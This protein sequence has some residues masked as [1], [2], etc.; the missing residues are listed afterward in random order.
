[1]IKLTFILFLFIFQAQAR[2]TGPSLKD[3]VTLKVFYTYSH[4]K[5]LKEPNNVWK[6]DMLLLIGNKASLYTSYDKL[7][8]R[9]KNK[10]AAE[11][12]YKVFTNGMAPYRISFSKDWTTTEYIRPFDNSEFLIQEYLGR[13]FWYKEKIVDAKWELKSG[14]KTLL[15]YKCKMAEAVFLGRKW[16]VWYTEDIPVNTGPWKL[17]GLPGLILEA[18]DDSG[19]VSMMASAIE[20]SQVKDENITYDKNYNVIQLHE[21]GR[22]KQVTKAEFE[23]LRIQALKDPKRFVEIQDQAM[24]HS[25]GGIQDLGLS[26]LRSIRPVP[27]NPIDLTTKN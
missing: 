5:N 2:Q 27:S 6:E 7:K 24:P 16:Q 20:G 26:A 12:H 4:V 23:K 21:L 14:T 9:T 10:K 22:S 17:G 3:Q 1:M 13:Y 11:D 18:R 19:K 15:G 8:E 25:Q